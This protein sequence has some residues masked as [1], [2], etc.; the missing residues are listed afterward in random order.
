M[1]DGNQVLATTTSFA[2]KMKYYP[3]IKAQTSGKVMIDLQVGAFS[4]QLN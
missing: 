2:R 3:E 1:N 4:Y